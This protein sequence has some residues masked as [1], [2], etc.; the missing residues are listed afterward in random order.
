MVAD[1]EDSSAGNAV[2]SQIQKQNPNFVFVLGDLGYESNL[3][4]FKETYGTLGDKMFC[5]VGN[6]EAD[7]EDGSSSLEKETLN[8]CGNTYWIKKG[9]NLFI[10]IN[11]NDKQDTL[12][13]ALDTKIFKNTTVMNGVK[14]IHINGHK[15]CA[16][17]PNSHHPAGEIKVL[18]DFIKSKIPAGV[19]AF[20][21]SGHNHVLSQSAEKVFSQVGGGGKSHYTCGTNA[22]FPFCNNT[23]YGYMLYTIKLDGT[24]TS[25][26]ID[27]TGVKIYP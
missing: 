21:N 22:D 25:Q 19:K 23:K 15:G 14:S 1:V 13:S 6:H 10:M 17:P 2:F 4:W 5:V 26:F 9:A 18:C 24:T 27:H 16:T 8:F 7:N 11:T 20:F 12:K 3:Q